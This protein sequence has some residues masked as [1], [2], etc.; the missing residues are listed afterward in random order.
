MQQTL[1]ERLHF[2]T[3]TPVQ[4]AVLPLLV[5]QH[6]DV[7]VRAVT[8]SG[9]SLAFL[10]PIAELIRTRRITTDARRKRG[11]ELLALVLAPTRELALQ[12]SHV[13]DV[14]FEEERIAHAVVIGGSGVRADDEAKAL[15]T[16]TEDDD[17]DNDDDDDG[18]DDDDIT[19]E[20]M[21]ALKKKVKKKKMMKKKK[22][23][24]I[25]KDRKRKK[26]RALPEVII[27]TPGRVLDVLPRIE[28]VISLREVL[29]LVLDEADRLLSLGFEREVLEIIKLLPRQRRT[30]LFSATQGEAV[31]ELV[32]KAGMRN[33]VRVTVL[34]A[35]EEKAD[36]RAP[37][38]AGAIP[39]GLS[40]YYTL[41]ESDA[42]FS[43]LSLF[44]SRQC[45]GLKCIV[46]F[47]TCACVDLA[48]LVLP[49]LVNG[50]AA[51]H[52]ASMKK[53]PRRDEE[54][55]DDDDASGAS[56][57]SIAFVHLHGRMKQAAREKALRSF[58]DAEGGA[59]LLATDVAARGLDIPGVDWVIQADPPQDP[60]AFIHRI[61]RT[62]RMGRT[63]NSLVYL[64]PH[65]EAYVDLLIARRVPMEQ[66]N[67]EEEQRTRSDAIGSR[68]AVEKMRRMSVKDRAVMEKATRAFV[69]YVRAYKEHHCRF[70]FMFKELDLGRLA[71]AFGLLRLPKMPELTKADVSNFD[72]ASSSPPL[73]FKDV[74]VDA[75]RY[76]DKAREKQRQKLL[77]AKKEEEEEAA[78]AQRDSKADCDGLVTR[79][80]NGDTKQQHARAKNG[81]GVGGRRERASSSSSS[82]PHQKTERPQLKKTE[83]KKQRNQD[84]VDIDNDYRLLKKL[85]RGKISESEYLRLAEE[86]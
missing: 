63:G 1:C 85:K 33:P 12:L 39:T 71:T 28:H 17:D 78:A 35:K 59:V 18:D 31:E 51:I 4:N 68:S 77:K 11:G 55:D 86:L 50:R 74:D 84:L 76:K 56:T 27:G 29:A 8:G 61:G 7:V 57:D 80:K 3:P 2:K 40:C 9:K 60:A 52:A 64:H 43:Q 83:R 47:I 45:R 65:E 5:K 30:G 66:R 14:V 22:K 41:C 19:E 62:A 42:L 20:T 75:I 34:Q 6:K 13:A 26:Q 37:A 69:S 58:A 38:S 46:Y 54:D 16:I 24:L 10:L 70:I 23:K 72:I 82:L 15:V 49:S 53:R 73:E 67:P 36:A 48:A 32:K 25:E 44:L 21:S 79:G 81:R